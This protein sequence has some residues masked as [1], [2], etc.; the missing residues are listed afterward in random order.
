MERFFIFLLFYISSKHRLLGIKK[1]ND[2][3]NNGNK[4]R[5]K[6]T[7]TTMFRSNN[8]VEPEASGTQTVV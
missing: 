2:Q 4:K 3:F 7:R 1:K 8:A 6:N 5:T